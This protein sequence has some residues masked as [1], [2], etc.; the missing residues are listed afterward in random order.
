MSIQLNVNNPHF[1]VMQGRIALVINMKPQQTLSFLEEASGTSLYENRKLASLKLI[2]K[3]QLKV[4][5]ISSI[6]L[7]E[8]LP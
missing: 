4:D 2:Q 1:L 8:I 5:E 7:Q 6:V 3:K